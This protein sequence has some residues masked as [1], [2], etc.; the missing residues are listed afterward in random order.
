M[1]NLDNK[2]Y[3]AMPFAVENFIKKNKES[4]KPQEIKIL[5]TGYI[6][7]RFKNDIDLEVK[8]INVND[9]ELTDSELIS[10][11]TW[12]KLHP[13]KIAGKMTEQQSSIFPVKCVG[14]IEDIEKIINIS[15]I[16]LTELKLIK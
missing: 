16:Q 4:L 15:F 2:Y 11:D 6:P 13:E 8:N 3:R 9:K 7:E 14:K 5:S 10:F 12:Y 1:K